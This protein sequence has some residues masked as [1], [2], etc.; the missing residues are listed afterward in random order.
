MKKTILAISFIA[1]VC[2]DDA[3]GQGNGHV[4]IG[5]ATPGAKLQVNHKSTLQSPTI[6][7]YDSTGGTGSKMS[8]R[9]QGSNQEF[10][11]SYDGANLN[12]NPKEISVD[13]A[14]PWQFKSNGRLGFGTTNPQG[15]M[16]I[17][18][19]SG[20]VDPA[21]VLFDSSNGNGAGILFQ[22]QSVNNSFA[23]YSDGNDLYFNPKELTID[24]PVPWQLK[25]SGRLGVFT[26]TPQGL[27]QINN[28]S[29]FGNPSIVLYD[30]TGGNGSG[31]SFRKQ[32][33]SREFVMQSDGANLYFNPKDVGLDKDTYG[34]KFSSNGQ[35]GIGTTTPLGFVQVN[36][37]STVGMPSLVLFDS[38]NGTGNMLAFRKQGLNQ[39][40]R[41]R[42]ALGL[43]GQELEI[44][45]LDYSNGGVTHEDTWSTS[46]FAMRSNGNIGM[47]TITP[48]ARLQINNKGTAQIPALLL[49]DSTA[50]NGKML[51]LQKQNSTKQFRM[52]LNFGG[53]ELEVFS[54]GYTEGGV[55]DED[56]W[57]NN[58]FT[59]NS[60]GNAGIGTT[61][62]GGRMQINNKASNAQPTF[63]LMDSATGNGNAISF[64]KQGIDKGFRIRS[65]PAAQYPDGALNFE[66]HND[67]ELYA[68]A[69]LTMRGDGKVGINNTSPANALDV[70]GDLNFT[71][72]LKVGGNMGVAG[73]VLTSNGNNGSPA[74]QFPIAQPS[75]FNAYSDSFTV[76]AATVV[77]ALPP[78]ERFDN[79]NDYNANTGEFVA[80]QPSGYALNAHVAI[81]AYT[82]SGGAQTM[83]WVL[84]ILNAN[85]TLASKLE[86]TER[87]PPNSPGQCAQFNIYTIQKLNTGQKARLKVMHSF[88]G[89]V[90][91][92]IVDEFSAHRIL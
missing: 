59:M 61:T 71:G 31:V 69:L 21:I 29:G 68:A 43:G 73:Q 53:Q 47:G 63:L 60:R 80:P 92:A 13:K 10:E 33:S 5:T 64:R 41:M 12:Y 74:W 1:T 27:I 62:P 55:T 3:L 67:G 38:T 70:N 44:F 40:F 14:V 88:G 89:G 91:R 54:M 11:I 7:V 20:A 85:S 76:P 26:S 46:G 2:M 18:H 16:Q 79:L 51:A 42:T 22:K 72:K 65:N 90:I 4:G 87:V 81:C 36:N 66:V 39:Q 57:A 35:T 82:G 58:S 9:K 83:H 45:S 48:A 56:S 34:W 32:A 8:F 30:S 37:R 75:G 25:N 19:R 86:K 50:G 15:R 6:V 78:N 23:I 17:N 52:R 77:V 84:E 49:F 24:K 28:K